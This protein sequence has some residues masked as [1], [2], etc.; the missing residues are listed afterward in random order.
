MALSKRSTVNRALQ[1]HRKKRIAKNNGG[2]ALPTLPVDHNFDIPEAFKEMVLFDSGCGEARVIILGNDILLDGLGRADIWLADGTFSVVPTIFFQL[3]S[4]HFQFG[5]GINPAA[6]YC[7]LTNKTSVSYKQMLD[8]VKV[9]VPTAN[10][11]KILVDFERAAIT[12]F[13]A[14]FPIATVTGCY[15]HLTQS[16]IRKVN[17]ISM[18]VDYQT[19]EALRTCVRCLPALAFVP[20]DD[21][22]EA[23]D[24]LAESIVEHEHMNELL[25]FFEHTYVRGRR[26]RG[27][28]DV[29]GP[30]LFNIT[31]WNQH[32]AAID[33]IAR[34]TN[35]VEGWHHGLQSLFHCHHPTMWTFLT[36]IK[37]DMFKQK[38]LLLQAAAGVVHPPRKM[39]SRLQKR[40]EAAIA[41]YG[42]TEILVFLRAMS[43]LSHS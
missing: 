5:S 32:G 15:F 3:Y 20:P 28:G 38:A 43:H 11:R 41:A 22:L 36:G 9:L 24:L 25:S 19:N 4:I 39:Y 13:E 34:T 8:A 17:E 30:A 2:A 29:Y 1:R 7:L 18:K 33:G 21:V 26:R 42:R 16:V 27:R 6:L 40:V 23:F 37:Q 35:V 31:L 12:A 10:P 14:A